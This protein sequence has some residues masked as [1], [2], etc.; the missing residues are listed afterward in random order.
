[1]Y[2]SLRITGRLVWAMLLHAATDPVTI[3]AVGGIDAHG[4]STGSTSG[5]ITVA[6]FFNW[7]YILLALVT[8]FLVKN[9]DRAKQEQA[10]VK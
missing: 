8:I 10:L 3:L 5:L 9:H 2:L 1:M 6:G 7:I 4:D